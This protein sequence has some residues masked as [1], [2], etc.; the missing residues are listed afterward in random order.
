[1]ERCISCAAQQRIEAKKLE[2]QS[3]NQKARQVKGK[4]I[5]YIAESVAHQHVERSSRGSAPAL[6]SACN[7]VDQSRSCDQRN[8]RM[9]IIAQR[10]TIADMSLSGQKQTHHEQQYYQH[11]SSKKPTVFYRLSKKT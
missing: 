8:R 6:V 10:Q 1:M 5:P 2:Q 7:T 3:S 9:L 11:R 4:K